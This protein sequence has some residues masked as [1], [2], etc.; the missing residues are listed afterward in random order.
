MTDFIFSAEKP[1]ESSGKIDIQLIISVI[2]LLGLARA[3]SLK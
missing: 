3:C 2:L 1:V